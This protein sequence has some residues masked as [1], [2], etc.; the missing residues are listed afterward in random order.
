MQ[1]VAVIERAHQ[2]QAIFWMHSRFN[3]LTAAATRKCLHGELQD[4]AYLYIAEQPTEARNMLARDLGVICGDENAIAA[5]D[6]ILC[7]AELLVSLFLRE[8]PTS[9]RW[10]KN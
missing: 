7:S 2:K 9:S 10:V 4:E 1:T 6:L 8:Y 3:R 5:E